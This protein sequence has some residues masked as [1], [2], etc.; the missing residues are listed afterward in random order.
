VA[1]LWLAR[2]ERQVMGFVAYDCANVTN[3]VNA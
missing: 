3:S 1:M 2:Q